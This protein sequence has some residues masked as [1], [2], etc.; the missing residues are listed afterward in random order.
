[1]RT[2]TA[3]LAG[4]MAL[5]LSLTLT[6]CDAPKA[7][8]AETA[9][10]APAGKHRTEAITGSFGRTETDCTNG[11]GTVRTTAAG[12]SVCDVVTPAS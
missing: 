5:G 10:A 9:Q 11:G 2:T 8:A 1:M 6:G 7:P 4:V 3:L 12:A